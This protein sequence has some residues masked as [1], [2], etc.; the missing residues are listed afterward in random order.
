[1]HQGQDT[2]HLYSVWFGLEK[3][4]VSER[5]CICSKRLCCIIYVSLQNNIKDQVSKVDEKVKEIKTNLISG[6][7]DFLKTIIYLS[8][9]EAETYGLGPSVQ[10]GVHYQSID[11]WTIKLVVITLHASSLTQIIVLI[12]KVPANLPNIFAW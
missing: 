10:L 1:M 12:P 7:G 2:S 6:L 9:E 4:N 5:K 8:S 3:E 11:V